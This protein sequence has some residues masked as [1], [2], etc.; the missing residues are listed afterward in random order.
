MRNDLRPLGGNDNRGTGNTYGVGV[1]GNIQLNDGTFYALPSSYT[2]FV[3]PQTG[4]LLPRADEVLPGVG[5]RN[6][7]DTADYVNF[8]PDR[9]RRTWYA[10]LRW[11]LSDS[12][13]IQYTG[14]ISKRHSISDSFQMLNVSVP[15]DSPLYIPGIAPAGQSY[16]VHYSTTA[17][18]LPRTRLAT[19]E[20]RNHYV[21]VRADI[22][23]GW[24]VNGSF[25][26]GDTENCGN[27]GNEV[28]HIIPFEYSVRNP[29]LFNPYATGGSQPGIAA[30]HGMTYHMGWGEQTSYDLRFEGPVIDLPAGEVRASFGGN[31]TEQS[32]RLKLDQDV[33][34]YDATMIVARDAPASRNIES[35]FA[36]VFVPVVPMLDLNLALR[37][38]NYSDFGSTTNPKVGL[39][40]Y[41]SSD[42][43]VSATWGKAFR[44]ATLTENNPGVSYGAGASEFTNNTGDPN[45]PI[46]HPDR[47]TTVLMT[48][49]GNSEDLAPET[50]EMYSIGATYTPEAVQGLN[51]NVTYYKVDY[52]DR[53]ETVPGSNSAL[54]SPENLAL[55]SSFLTPAPQPSTCV[56]GDIS[57]YNPIYIPWLTNPNRL[58]SANFANECEAVALFQTGRQN[59][60]RVV[61]TGVDVSAG[62]TWFN[63]MG[64]W[65]LSGSASKILSYERAFL[66]DQALEDV[67]DRIGFQVSER[68]RLKVGWRRESWNVSL[69]SNYIG[70]YTNISPI[71]VNGQS[72]GESRVPS[73]TT[74]DASI[75]YTVPDTDL[76]LL[77]DTR[78]TFA[79]GNIQD[80]QP[81]I[82]LSGTN[83]FDPNVHDPLGR[84]FML[85]ISKSFEY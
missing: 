38:D 72:L 62:Y 69:S 15:V 18:G 78:I 30:M 46:T 49:S 77:S 12:V 55:Y 43:T 73:W 52:E 1:P 16:S 10:K 19:D 75:S 60:G 22:I 70:S 11:D 81:P 58:A 68:A 67:L 26:W 20:A 39:N 2:G 84:Q 4:F 5:Q 79:I 28:N 31:Y 83:G 82:V 37:R 33:R 41:P 76:S 54:S 34:D 21:D 65:S 35:I 42:L 56:P 23:G 80:K 24:Q 40:F 27:C 17:E 13:E 51:V 61:Q 44:A 48:R 85:E 29:G 32:F 74:L 59:T 36:E 45:F 53:L 50:A 9:K 64:E 57:T 6:L 47:G 14:L 25:M 7:L 63:Q 8:L 66:P 3:D 71:T